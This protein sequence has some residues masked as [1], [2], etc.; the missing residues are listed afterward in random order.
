[1]GRLTLDETI[2]FA[3]KLEKQGREFYRECADN[4][5]REDVQRMFLFLAMQE[6]KH[7]A[8]FENMRASYRDNA[9]EGPGDA[10]RGR[11][12]DAY[13]ESFFP[14]QEEMKGKSIAGAKLADVLSFAMRIEKTSVQYYEKLRTLL[15]SEYVRVVE[16]IIGE[17]KK[18][19]AKLAKFRDSLK[20]SRT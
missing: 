16:R 4:A 11:L 10:A 14:A 19:Y 9:P 2:Q 20:N 17:E 6:G 8:A 13:A 1:M 12:M 3:I 18:H 5:G 15:S 7:Q